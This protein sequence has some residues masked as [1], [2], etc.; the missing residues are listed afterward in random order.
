LDI[1]GGNEDQDR[2]YYAH[3]RKKQG[4]C[5]VCIEGKQDLKTA[6]KVRKRIKR[7]R[8]SYE[9]ITTD[10]WDSFLSAFAED[11]HKHTVGIDKE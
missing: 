3:H 6:L 4:N 5:G 10:N 8:I 11:N 9:R 7:M 1:G 2:A